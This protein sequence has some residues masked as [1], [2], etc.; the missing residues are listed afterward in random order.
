LLPLCV[1]L[2]SQCLG[3]LRS[4]LLR[5][6]LWCV[7]VAQECGK[8]AVLDICGV[9][10]RWCD[11]PAGRRCQVQNQHSGWRWLGCSKTQGQTTLVTKPNQTQCLMI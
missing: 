6:S 5:P 4:L 7:C 2:W 9:W 11:N 1:M 10:L 8:A 3:G